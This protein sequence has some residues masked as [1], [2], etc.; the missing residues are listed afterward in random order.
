MTLSTWTILTSELFNN[1]P[2][3]ANLWTVNK[4]V[5]HVMSVA[6]TGK[7]SEQGNSIQQG[8]IFQSSAPSPWWSP[9][10]SPG[11]GQLPSVILVSTLTLPGLLL[12]IPQ[13]HIKLFL[14]I[15]KNQALSLWTGDFLCRILLSFC[16]CRVK[17]YSSY[18]IDHKVQ[19]VREDLTSWL[20]RPGLGPLSVFLSC[21]LNFPSSFPSLL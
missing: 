11:C 2:L 21:S 13:K 4:H 19:S 9:G 1:S 10:E 3:R 8:D 12:I 16:L 14:C 6:N 17:F 7:F 18:R 5:L 20:L 15:G